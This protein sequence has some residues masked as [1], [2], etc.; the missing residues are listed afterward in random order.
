MKKVFK[1]FFL[2]FLSV[3]TVSFVACGGD[4]PENNGENGGNNGGGNGG[5]TAANALVEH[6]FVG[7][8]P[9]CGVFEY[10]GYN[11]PTEIT[12]SV[13]FISE[14]KCEVELDLNVGGTQQ[15]PVISSSNYTFDGT[16]GQFT[17]TSSQGGSMPVSFTYNDA[18]KTISFDL[19][20]GITASPGEAAQYIG[21]HFVLNRVA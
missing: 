11:L 20:L 4:D 14:S 1:Y 2:A 19:E 16:N 17:L 13:D 5:G 3:A 8:N 15:Q 18:A 21:G 10:N 7:T 6:S 9:D 12:A